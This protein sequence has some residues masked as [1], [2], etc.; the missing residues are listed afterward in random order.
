MDTIL[1]GGLIREKSYLIKGGPGTGKSTFGYHFLEEGNKK[2]ET[3]MLITLGEPEK[4]IRLNSEKQNINLADTVILDLGPGNQELVSEQNYSVFS[5]LEVEA[6]PFIKNVIDAIDKLNPSRVVLDSITMVKYLYQDSFQYKNMALSMIH[7]ICSSGATLLMISEVHQSAVEDEAEFWADG[8][9]EVKSGPYWRR[10]EVQKLRGSD[11]AEC[12]HAIRITAKG[13]EVFPRLQPNK[14]DKEFQNIA[15]SSGIDELDAMME[16]GIEKGTVS[17]ITGA[18]GVGKTNLGVQF[19]KAAAARGERSVMYTFEEARDVIINRSKLIGVPV[20]EM[21]SKG[22]L[23][24]K[25]IEPFSYSPDEFAMMVRE[26][27]EENDTRIVMIDSVGGYSL[28]VREENSLERLHALCTYLGNVGVTTILVSEM[29]SITG[30]FVTTNLNASY[31]ADNI[32]YLRYLEIDGELRKSVGILKKR[33]SDFEK[34][35]REFKITGEGIVIG[36]PM[37]NMRGIL[38]GTPQI[39]EPAK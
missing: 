26:D 5:P 17:M 21:I 32:I 6:E 13:V 23:Y 3:T 31:L 35:I 28:T 34:S 2:G 16:G 36:K 14:Y 25:S 37:S 8:V 22:Q 20:D 1:K 18:T 11:F 24:I 33:L 29:K 30:E 4:S 7:Q 10:A 19:M 9:I 38:S 15:L 27:V 39:T 12:D